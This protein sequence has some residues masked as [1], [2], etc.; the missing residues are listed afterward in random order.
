MFIITGAAGFIGSCLVKKLNDEG[1]TNIIV[2]DRLGE[3]ERWLNLRGL[4]Y[5]R[6]IHADDFI[7]PELMTDVFEEGVD[8][9]YHMGACSSTTEKNIDFLMS[10]N[11]EY[12]QILFSYCAH[13]DVP[14]CYASSAATY[15]AGE[16]GYSDN[17]ENISK[18][19][20]L[21]AY[22]YSKHLMDEWALAQQKVPS[23]WFGVK[24][25]NVY[26]P[27]EYH[28]ES[29]RSV[30]S[31]AFEQI[32]STR[33]MKLFK[34]HNKDYKDG[35][36]LRDF[37]YVKDVV[38][39]M[40]ELMHREHNGKNGIYNLGHGKA[41]SFKDL[42]TATF[43]AMNKEPSIKF[44]DMPEHLRSQYQYYTNAE[45]EKFHSVFPE[46]EFHSLE[47]GVKDYVQ[48]HLMKKDPYLNSRS[49]A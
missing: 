21:N 46:F 25:F 29:M 4:K 43:K 34:S 17:E 37:V 6:Y 26:G 36:Q 19:M 30:V 24:F 32:E 23:T 39:A 40:C 10:N 31:Q 2:V 27:N 1:H 49:E 13:Y 14:I 47:D 8:A 45:M 7:Q 41:R 5:Y 9:V 42:V 22:G 16:N 48:S 12:S 28:K 38:N 11:V 18:L 44:I 20:P 15:G 3:D 33:E 35:E